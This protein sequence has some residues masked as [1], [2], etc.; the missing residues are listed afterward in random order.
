MKYALSEV[1]QTSGGGDYVVKY[2]ADV[3]LLPIGSPVKVEVLST[4]PPGPDLP[5]V[6]MAKDCI[7]RGAESVLG[8][9]GAILRVSRL[10][11]HPTDFNGRRFE[12]F[13]AGGLRKALAD[14]THSSDEKN[15]D[16][17]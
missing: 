12:E 7:R 8:A 2:E 1:V 6:D 16:S 10:Y 3:E 13:T 15:L 17:K 4:L 5:M 11:I 9:R 14:D